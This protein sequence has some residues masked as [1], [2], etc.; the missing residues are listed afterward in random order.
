MMQR[1][2]SSLQGPFSE[3]AWSPGLTQSFQNGGGIDTRHSNG[4]FMSCTSFSVSQC[5]VIWGWKFSFSMR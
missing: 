3:K 4:P 5:S 1:L 2:G